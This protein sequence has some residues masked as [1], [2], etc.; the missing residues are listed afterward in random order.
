MCQ[1]SNTFDIFLIGLYP[2]KFPFWQSEQQ[3]D[4]SIIIV[5]GLP[6]SGTSLMMKM[7]EA[8]GIPLVVDNLRQADIDNPEGYYELEGV[9]ALKKGDV[10]W[11]ST[12][13]GCAVKV[14]SALL[15]H[16]PATYT[17]RVIFMQ[18]SMQEVLE[19]QRRM[20]IRRNMPHN[21]DDDIRLAALYA[22]HLQ[23]VEKWI[24]EQPNF[25]SLTVEYKRLLSESP[26]IAIQEVADFLQR[27]VDME[28]MRQAINPSLY[29]NRA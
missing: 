2:L 8:G 27:P 16:L 11:L 6:R 29:R 15:V 5:S 20:L 7:L 26:Q 23:N 14:I 19:S 13:Q 24:D 25:V 28:R 21:A 12:A 4:T 1:Q 3:N 22:R 18:R 10:E 17:Y 9:K